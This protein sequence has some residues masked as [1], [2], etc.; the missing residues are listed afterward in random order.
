MRLKIII[1]I[2]LF[3]IG[4]LVFESLHPRQKV[5]LLKGIK[6]N[7]LSNLDKSVENNK[8]DFSNEDVFVKFDD[9]MNRALKIDGSV[10]PSLV[11][12]GVKLA[13]LRKPLILA[14]IKDDPK[15]ALERSITWSQF[16]ALP[17]SIRTYLEEPFS[18]N[19]EWQVLPICNSSQA[20][21]HGNVVSMVLNDKTMVKTYSV[22]PFGR[23]TALQTKG[24]LPLQGVRIDTVAAVN[25]KIFQVLSPTEFS[26]LNKFFPIANKDIHLSATENAILPDNPIPAL[27]GRKIYLFASFEEL[28]RTEE[29]LQKIEKL[30][31]PQTRSIGMPMA[32]LGLNSVSSSPTINLPAISYAAAQASTNWTLTPK[33]M[34]CIVVDFPDKQGAPV[35]I[36]YLTNTISTLV[37]SNINNFSYGKSSLQVTAAPQALYRM[38]NPSSYYTN[39]FDNN[40]L[41]LDARN[42]C[43]NSGLDPS[44][45]DITL[46]CFANIGMQL[47]KSGSY[48]FVYAG[49]AGGSNQWIQ[50][51]ANWN[52]GNYVDTITHETG[53]NYGLG[54]AHSWDTTDGSVMS[55]NGTNT[56]YGDIFDS[57]AVPVIHPADYNPI[58]K[59]YLGWMNANQTLNLSNGIS[60]NR[61]YAFDCRS[62]QSNVP[63]ALRI[64]NG[65]SQAFV[66]GIRRSVSNSSYLNNGLYVL[67]DYDPNEYTSRLLDMT[68][69]SPLGKNDSPLSLNKTFTDPTGL[70]NITPIAQGGTGS[71]AWMDVAVALG[72]LIPQPAV[73]A[74]SNSF[75]GMARSTTTFT[76]S[77]TNS[78]NAPLYYSWDFGDGSVALGGNIASHFYQVGGTY[79]VTVTVTDAQGGIASKSCTA[80][81]TDP[82]QNWLNVPNSLGGIPS[83]GIYANGVW[84]LGGNSWNNYFFSADA[85]T[86]KT[87]NS[88]NNWPKAFAY[89]GG[90]FVSVGYNGISYST[91]AQ[92]WVAVSMSNADNVQSIAYGNGVF[93]AGVSGG[94]ILVSSNG[95]S[96]NAYTSPVIGTN[97]LSQIVFG[98]GV[99]L[100]RVNSWG[101]T[102]SRSLDGV[103]W[104]M[105][106][107]ST[108]LPTNTQ[109]NQLAYEP[110]LGIFAVIGWNGTSWSS[111]YTSTNGG[112]NWSA[113]SVPSGY[114]VY[115]LQAGGGIFA[116]LATSSNSTN[117]SLLISSDGMNWGAYP[118]TDGAT[119]GLLIGNGQILRLSGST[120]AD[121]RMAAIFAATPPVITMS[122]SISGRA[123]STTTFTCSATTSNNA[124][125]YYSWDFGDGSVGLGG[126]SASHIFQ[127]GGTYKVTLTVTD[128][129]GGIAS[130]S[131]TA[132]ISDPLQNW[133]NVTNASGVI[134]TLGIYANGAWI[135]GGNSWSNYLFSSDAATWK[136]VSLKN[137]WPNGFAY[138][139]GTYVS[140]G[141]GGISFS[142][143]GQSWVNGSMTNT[144]TAY[145]LAYGNGVFVAG[146]SGGSILVSSN[147]SNWSSYTS[148]AIGTNYLSQIV[149]GSGVFLSRVNYWGTGLCSSSDGVNWTMIPDSTGLPTNTQFNQLAYEPNH[150][151][152]AVTGWNGISAW[153]RVYTSTNGGSNWNASSVPS[154][155]SVYNLQAG[156]GIFAA[157]ATST[158][159]TNT[160][161]LISSDGMNWGAYSITDG[162]TNG[163]LIGNGQILRFNGSTNAPM[164]LAA[165]SPLTCNISIAG[166]GPCRVSSN[167]TPLTNELPHVGE[168]YPLYIQL[169]VTGT[170][171]PFD[172]VLEMGAQTTTYSITNSLKTGAGYWWWFPFNSNLDG[173]I[174]WKITVD[175]N[176]S[177]GNTNIS[178]TISG[179]FSPIPPS[180]AVYTYNTNFVKASETNI[181]NFQAGSGT[182]NNLA[183]MMGSP[184]D[185]PTQIMLSTNLPPN[186]QVIT[187]ASQGIKVCQISY[188]NVLAQTFTNTESFTA[189]LSSLA[190]NS[191]LLKQITWSQLQ[192][193]ID[194]SL[195]P[196]TQ[197]SAL[198]Q[199]TDPQISAFVTS[200][201]TSN[202]QATLSPYEA[203]RELHKAVAGYMSYNGITFFGLSALDGLKSKQGGCGNYATLLTACLRNIGIPAKLISGFRLGEN[204]FH[205]RV[206][207]YLPSAGWIIADACDCN[208][209][210]PTGSYAY[211]FGNVDNANQFFAID[212]GDSKFVNWGNTSIDC[213]FLQIGTFLWS[214]GANF[215]NNSSYPSLKIYSFQTLSSFVPIQNQTFSNGTTVTINPPIA[216]SGLPVLVTV[217]SGPA[218]ISSN[219]VS[220]IGAGTVVLAANQPGDSAYLAASEVTTSFEVS[221]GN[222]TIS[223]SVVPA[224]SVTNSPFQLNAAASSG[225]PVSYTSTSNNI[226]ISGNMVSILGGGTATIVASQAGDSNWNAATNITNSFV[227]SKALQSI[228]FFASIPNQIYSN[229]AT[230]SITPPSTSSGLPVILSVK[231]GPAIITGNLLTLTGTGVVVL[232]ANQPG[233]VRYA[234][235]PEVRMY[236]QSSATQSISEFVPV[237]NQIY[238]SNKTIGIIPPVAS[239]GLAVNVKVKSGPATI[240]G[241]TVSLT[242]A[243]TV[244]LVASQGGNSSYLPSAEVTTSFLVSKGLQSIVFGTLANHTFG[245]APITLNATVNSALPVSYTSSSTNVSISGNTLKILGVGTTTIIASQA[246]DSN[247]NTAFPVSQNL[248]IEPCSQ[249]IGEFP[250]IADH[251]FSNNAT[252]T[253]TPPISSSGLPVTI[254]V[255]SG[256]ASISE[257]IL[258]L[259]GTGNVVLVA[260]QAGDANYLPASPVSTGFLVGKGTQSISFPSLGTLQ[261]GAAPYPLTNAAASSGL[262]LAFVLSDTKVAKIT[263]NALTVLGLGTTTITA[264]QSGNSNWLA[265][266]PVS[267]TLI[268]GKGSQSIS[269]FGTIADVL[270][271]TNRTVTIPTPLPVAS[272]GLPVSL[273]VKSGPATL[274]GTTISISGTGVV[275]LAANQSGNTN[276]LAASEVM[277]SFTVLKLPQN[278]GSL[279]GIPA[280]TNGL[281]PFTVPI[282]KSSSGLPVALSILSGPAKLTNMTKTNCSVMITG[283]GTVVLAAD[284]VGNSNYLAAPQVS[285]SF[286]VA[287]GNQT[288][289]WSTPSKITNSATVVQL[290]AKSSSGLPVTYSTYAE[291]IRLTTNGL[292]TILGSGTFSITASQSGDENWNSASSVKQNLAV[293]LP[294]V[295]SNAASYQITAIA[296]A[297]SLSTLPVRP[298]TFPLARPSLSGSVIAWG[299]NTYGETTVPKGVTNIVQLSSRGIHS[300]ALRTNGS[301]VAWG[302]NAYGQTNVP[303][304][305]TNAVQVAAGSSFSMALKADGRVLAWGDNSLGQTNLPAGLSNVVQIAAGSHHGMALKSDG[306]VVSWGW[307]GY[308]QTNVPMDLTNV[309][310]IVGGYFHTAAL[311]ANGT[312]VAWG[313]DTYGET[314]IPPDLTN[315]VRIAAGLN[316][317][318]ALKSDG[319]VAAWGWDSAG[320]IDVPVTLSGVNQIAA[321][322]NTSFAVTTNGTLVT[323]G[324]NSYGQC[325]P[326]AGVTGIYQFVL[327]LYH[328]IGLKK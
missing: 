7:V 265:A 272:S 309:I 214:G 99:F 50:A 62:P 180:T 294:T 236:F 223:F 208:S 256:S 185:L 32:D 263:N 24:N 75:L 65:N 61:I 58:L 325:K 203:A 279:T 155:Y 52:V 17:S 137:N 274:K 37:G 163:L 156:G 277:T 39:N 198:V 323:W 259:N 97:Y 228:G 38:P 106:P 83:L 141:F 30:P 16:L 9:W 231:S 324:D 49:L 261:F 328:A 241:N 8:S 269:A 23:R 113:S 239:S 197:P 192:N 264:S 169:N 166:G 82:L 45:F 221:K 55:T 273:R 306:G 216:S 283:A 280:K 227:I 213:Q 152:F 204:A 249:F 229:G 76:C 170:A 281:P 160:S 215:I 182:I 244:V 300:L 90:N 289:S 242:G 299:D 207:F 66:V 78:N 305:L 286:S 230:L 112:T 40:Q 301:V 255:M 238:G 191:S 293:V 26:S 157:L 290:A 87:I 22:N 314:D 202:Y 187:T 139:R 210:D 189:K 5:G 291:H 103:N 246:G 68:P 250:A 69:N 27:A 135:L 296:S 129:Q 205:V 266:P 89:G 257:N 209:V 41:H 94:S 131:C 186:A 127:V 144:G 34:L 278:I 199:S 60:T 304:S 243:G 154:G 311:K 149:F 167:N 74:M 107:D 165:I 232:A 126:N 77:A 224:Q 287:K 48:N 6:N 237:P 173:S 168:I 105:I 109:F 36:N 122:N 220:V 84:I 92:D 142:T 13:K 119:N 218:T 268:I 28:Q 100:S 161:L 316:H 248:V 93:V 79:K 188:T 183:I 275:T 54:H 86:W 64:Q 153:S 181:L 276:Y 172:L 270:Y 72:P 116:A 136:T 56:E 67:W 1:F 70:V 297:S 318:L 196:F 175:P 319:T 151:I 33:K 47:T 81:I 245:D 111:V 130:K 85:A 233:D 179:T 162:A 253:I 43:N 271:A 120:N 222:Q 327:G 124:S 11:K 42:L 226:T 252:M 310:Q 10:D 114:S 20:G 307:N 35:D 2:T 150:G 177:S 225:L 44:S 295:S 190:V 176:N 115:N 235:A 46:V 178:N 234:P 292:V 193:G 260:N 184:P 57:M 134:P 145:S 247:W 302:W 146:L 15:Q 125:L 63:L 321:G 98:S 262:P 148:P 212:S 29:A 312:V 132:N 3:L 96:W 31:G 138:G 19:A 200:H 80:N 12:E 18:E 317:T 267:R 322:G 21:P 101:T 326:P 174:P 288:I 73:I 53:H 195:L 143:N 95:S 71:N 240:S 88:P 258:T 147:G 102:L 159:S 320:Q 206:E 59:S 194:A 158:N 313:D 25:E 14:L 303:L 211:Y 251:S 133:S 104:T 284:Q 164:Q 91:N 315:V 171:Q 121:M 282:P 51:G 117:T 123:R 217:K 110:N 128:A 4:F 298:S 201:L 140:V 219:T 118:I 108:G 285:T 254:S 308:G